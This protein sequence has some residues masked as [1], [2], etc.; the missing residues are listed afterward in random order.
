MCADLFFCNT[1]LGFGG[2]QLLVGEDGIR[3]LS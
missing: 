2:V 3:M 1:N